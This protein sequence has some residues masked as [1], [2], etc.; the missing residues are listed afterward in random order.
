VAVSDEDIA[1]AVDLFSGLGDITT[2][3]MMGGLCLYY[4]GTIFAMLRSD[5]E[6]LLKGAGDFIAKL[7]S[8]GSEQWRYVRS[9]GK[10]GTMPYWPLPEAARDDPEAATALARE[11]LR[12]L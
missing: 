2:R 9:N 5:G 1:H 10:A 11:A 3:K 12:H 7:E 4:E 8:M 6:I